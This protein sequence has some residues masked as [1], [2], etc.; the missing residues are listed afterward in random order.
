[1]SAERYLNHP[2]FGLMYRVCPAG[3][4]QEV[5][6]TL[7]AQRM[8]F[9][10]TLHGR[11][12]GFEP[13]PLLDARFLAEQNLRREKSQRSTELALWQKLFEQTFI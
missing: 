5:Y 12:A 6:A 13:M 10:V 4:D 11:G 7:Y 8:F 3:Q 1:V 9:R 2:T